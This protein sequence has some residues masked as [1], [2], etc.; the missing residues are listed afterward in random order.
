MLD[1]AWHPEAVLDE[2]ALHR[3]SIAQ[4]GEAREEP[5]QR[6]AHLIIGVEYDRA[7]PKPPISNRQT[8]GELAAPGLVE[9]IATHPGLQDMQFRGEQRALNAQ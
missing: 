1:Q 9:Q 5:R 2:V 3:A 4:Q 7:V 8:E 6:L